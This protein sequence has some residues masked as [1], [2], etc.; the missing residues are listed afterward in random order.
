MNESGG[1][2][3]APHPV[4]IKRGLESDLSGLRDVLLKKFLPAD[5]L[6]EF[7]NL[8]ASRD[9]LATQ[10]VPGFYKAHLRRPGS[11]ITSFSVAVGP[12]VTDATTFAYNTLEPGTLVLHVDEAK[13]VVRTPRVE[14]IIAP[15]ELTDASQRRITEEASMH[16]LLLAYQEGI[17][18]M[19]GERAEI[20]E[21]IRMFRDLSTPGAQDVD[22]KTVSE[23]L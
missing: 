3:I 11:E 19:L 16:D 1:D 14:R 18:R 5:K 15:G 9:A 21:Q 23:T 12:T 10:T 6:Q 20:Q 17:S 4:E 13:G 7:R 8:G 22:L 2:G